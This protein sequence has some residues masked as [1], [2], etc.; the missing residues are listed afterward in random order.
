M[1][2]TSFGH[3]LSWPLDD[4]GSLNFY[5]SHLFFLFDFMDKNVLIYLILFYLC[6]LTQDALPFMLLHMGHETS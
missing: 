4:S 1:C 5:I 2:S 3:C 6:S